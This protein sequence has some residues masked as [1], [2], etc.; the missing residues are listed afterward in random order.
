MRQEVSDFRDRIGKM[1]DGRSLFRCR[2]GPHGEVTRTFESRIEAERFRSA[3]DVEQHGDTPPIANAARSTIG[4]TS[5]A[6]IQHMEVLV[7]KDKKDSKTV[8]DY[9]DITKRLVSF[10]GAGR[11]LETI[12]LE[13][14]R[15]YVR[16]RLTGVIVYNGRQVQTS[17]ARVLKELKFLERLARE[18]GVTLRWSTKKHFKD[19]LAESAEATARKRKAVTPKQANAFIANLKG[20]DRA[21]VITKALTLMRNQELY[22]LRVRDIDLKA[23]LI[24]YIACAKRKKVATVALLPP[25]VRAEI[26]P[27]M[28]GRTPDAWLFTCEGRKVQQSSFRKRF[29][30]A[31]KAAGLGEAMELDDDKELGG[32]G[33][34]RH[35]VMTALRPRVG[36]DAVSK[37]A[38]HA[39]VAVT[40]AIYD[41]DK[42]ALDLK[43]QAVEV[44]R[45]VFKFGPSQ[46]KAA[47][48]AKPKSSAPVP[49][50]NLTPADRR[51]RPV[52]A[53]FSRVGRKSSARRGR[54]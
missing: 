7:I 8:K 12:G 48:P 53:G 35:A 14:A 20:D 24:R 13:A 30:K 26:L 6:L 27:L 51:L 50:S 47:P 42:E 34:I 16:R 1:G 15:D 4:S 52:P 2:R 11:T 9:R 46:R 21:F 19:D 44:V 5:E 31:S 49:A 43:S 37:Y 45:T 3:H 22:N 17:G 18:S 23:G 38:N 29:V 10:F 40:E 54:P 41:L 32:V 39:S 28:T 33:W 25:E 36:I